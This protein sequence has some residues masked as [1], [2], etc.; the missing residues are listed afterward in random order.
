MCC[1][2]LVFELHSDKDSYKSR[3]ILIAVCFRRLILIR[4]FSCHFYVGHVI[5][6][7]VAK[8]ALSFKCDPLKTV[9][10]M[11]WSC[12]RPVIADWTLNSRAV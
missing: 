1:A 7:A 6:V 5:A 4:T 10:V 2:N 11:R 3:L 12:N 9:T 8:G